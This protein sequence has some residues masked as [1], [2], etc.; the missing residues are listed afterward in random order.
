MVNWT[1]SFVNFSLMQVCSL[2]LGFSILDKKV[3][4]PNLIRVAHESRL[5]KRNSFK[6]IGLKC[7]KLNARSQRFID[8]PTSYS[9]ESEIAA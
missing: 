6:I 1:N 4:K 9:E 3:G 8:S 7:V 5:L 2:K